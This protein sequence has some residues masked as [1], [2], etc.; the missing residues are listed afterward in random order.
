[1]QAMIF[2][3]GCFFWHGLS[4]SHHPGAGTPAS[5]DLACVS[6]GIS[7]RP[8]P[9]FFTVHQNESSR[10]MK[11]QTPHHQAARKSFAS[12][13]LLFRW[14]WPAVFRWHVLCF[15]GGIFARNVHSCLPTTYTILRTV[16][17]IYTSSVYPF[18]RIPATIRRCVVQWKRRKWL[19]DSF[20]VA[21]PSFKVEMVKS[22]VL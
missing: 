22:S 3:L 11:K 17:I 15:E 13:L 20:T 4:P 12:Q 18:L 14:L 8:P 7:G 19:T 10:C 5:L 1:M 6:T 16:L 21:L 9:C 2:Y